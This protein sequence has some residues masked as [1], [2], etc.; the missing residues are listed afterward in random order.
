MLMKTIQALSASWLQAPVLYLSAAIFLLRTVDV[1][2]ATLRMFMVARGNRAAAWIA[3]ALQS[4]IFITLISGLLS[5][6]QNPLNLI[7]FAAGFATGNV[8]GVTIESRL[9]PGHSL[10]RIVSAKRGKAIVESLHRE[11]RGATEIPAA[12][13]SGMV[14][15]IL[16]FIPRREVKGA[17]ESIIDLDPEAYISAENVRL[18]G[19]GWRP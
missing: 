17:A 3:A 12:G 19:G 16:S 6:L 9:A 2:I 11:Q 14:S 8:L 4:L 13:M 10:M 15:L 1:T 18:L 5:N 7:A